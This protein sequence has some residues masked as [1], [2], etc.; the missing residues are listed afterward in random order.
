MFSKLMSQV[1]HILCYNKN[2]RNIFKDI[3]GMK[4]LEVFYKNNKKIN[5]FFLF[6]RTAIKSMNQTTHNIDMRWNILH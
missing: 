2:H 1:Q 6:K 5:Y 3:F 4:T